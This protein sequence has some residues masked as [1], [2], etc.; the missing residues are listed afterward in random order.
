MQ[1]R[2]RPRGRLA[3]VPTPL[4]RT[5]ARQRM[6]PWPGLT[7]PS[8]SLGPKRREDVDA[9]DKPGHDGRDT[10]AGRRPSLAAVDLTAHDRDGLLID[11]CGIPRLDRCKIGLTRLVACARAPAMR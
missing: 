5:S 8:T 4:P 6:P 1:S 11:A 2:R 3:S 9:R 7:R 10:L